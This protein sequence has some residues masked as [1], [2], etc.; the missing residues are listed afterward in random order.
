MNYSLKTLYELALKILKS[1]Y[2]GTSPNEKMN[3]SLCSQPVLGV[4]HY[5]LCNQITF[6]K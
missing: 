6:F 2:T 4:T 1:T 5:K 3:D